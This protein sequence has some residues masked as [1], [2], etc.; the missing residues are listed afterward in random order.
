[1]R[2]AGTAE[3]GRMMRPAVAAVRFALAVEVGADAELEG[4]D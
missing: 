2:R 1:M 4:G 3:D